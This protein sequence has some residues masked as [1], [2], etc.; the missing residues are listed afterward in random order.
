MKIVALLLIAFVILLATFPPPTKAIATGGSN[1]KS[2]NGGS[3]LTNP[4]LVCFDGIAKNMELPVESCR[5]LKQNQSCLCDIIKKTI[6]DSNV[7]S[8]SLKSCGIP[9][10][11][12]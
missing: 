10:L 12:C 4:L 7:L 9:D 6:L 1:S 8:S 11:K 2:S 5:R 3:C